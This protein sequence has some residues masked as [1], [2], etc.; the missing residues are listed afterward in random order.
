MEC[1]LIPAMP[2]PRSILRVCLALSLAFTLAPVVTAHDSAADFEAD[3]TTTAKPWT[4]LDFQ[5][6]PENFQFAVVSDRTGSPRPGVFQD[7]VKKLNLLMPEFVISVGDLIQGTSLNAET[8]DAEWDEAMGWVEPLKMPFFF[9]AG[10]HDIQMKWLEGRVQPEEMLAQWNERFGPTHYSFVYKDVLFVVLFTNDGKEQ[11]IG[12]EQVAYFEQTMAEHQDVRWTFVLLHHPL[13]VYPH[14]SNFSR[15]EAALQERKHTVLAGHQHRYVHFD[16]NDSDYIILASTGG[17]SKLRGHAFGEF[18]HFAWFTMTADGPVMAN[19]DLK[20]ILPKDL[21]DVQSLKIVRSIEQSADI[22][23][24][25][26][27]DVTEGGAVQGGSVYVEITNRSNQPLTVRGQFQHNHA[28]H[29][30]PGVID[31]RLAGFESQVIEVS[32]NVVAPLSV[33]DA[34]LLELDLTCQLGEHEDLAI[35]QSVAIPLQPEDHNLLATEELVFVDEVRPALTYAR[36]D[37]VV[38]FTTD[39]TKPTSS[40]SQVQGPL[41]FTQTTNLQAR[42]FTRGGVPG[43]VDTMRLTRVPPGAG[44]LARYYEHDNSEGHVNQ[45]PI[46]AGLPATFSKQVTNFDLSQIT[47]REEDFAVVFHGW[48]E[49]TEAGNYGFHV[50]S[51]DGVLLMIDGKDVVDDQ[52]KHP[53][54]ETSG[55]AQLGVGRHA[56]ELHFFQANRDS[57]LELE[58]TL[59]SGQRRPLP[60]A[61][62]SFDAES[63]PILGRSE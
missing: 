40:S 5:N 25:L 16:R 23:T 55:F 31:V 61:A 6:D 34:A 11:F 32:L 10:N 3:V 56:I 59:P 41:R 12:E 19:L 62:L 7:A 37:R 53:R 18:D 44:L 60:D 27:L 14:E 48:L 8:N 26:I 9:A 21:A 51:A 54:R 39:G 52:I 38:R 20:G 45:M 4:H 47:R 43:P 63:L 36:D 49:I 28:V 17:G 58:Y 30:S 57:F 46:F 50:D 42:V 22:Q 33:A 35:Q 15:I 24:N 13:W 1:F 29:P 2:L